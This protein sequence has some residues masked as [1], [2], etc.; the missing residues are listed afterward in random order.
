M[1]L[2]RSFMESFMALNIVTFADIAKRYKIKISWD[3]RRVLS[4]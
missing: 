1:E 2:N 3:V 4:P